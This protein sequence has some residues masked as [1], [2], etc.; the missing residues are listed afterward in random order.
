MSFLK[1]AWLTDPFELSQFDMAMVVLDPSTPDIAEPCLHSTG[2]GQPEGYPDDKH[3]IPAMKRIPSNPCYPLSLAVMVLWAI[4]IVS[5]IALLERSAAV[6]PTA[7]SQPWY[8]SNN[9]LPSLFF[10]SIA[11]GHGPVTALHLIR[12]AVSVL[13]SS[14]VLPPRTWTELFWLADRNL[15][16]ALNQTVFESFNT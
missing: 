5:E 15:S 9:G 8:Y 3:S 14:S 12:L 4:L 16:W 7:L 2:G 6:A 10:T 1:S 13:H 11:Q